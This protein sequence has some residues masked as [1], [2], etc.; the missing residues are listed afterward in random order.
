MPV[1]RELFTTRGS[2]V[3]VF[4]TSLSL[5]LKDQVVEISQS[6]PWFTLNIVGFS[7]ISRVDKHFISR[8]VS[9]VA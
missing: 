7:S 9:L 4:K 1:S 3:K 2:K 8:N 5:K 6:F